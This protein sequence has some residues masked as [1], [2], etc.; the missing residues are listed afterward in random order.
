M[1]KCGKC[2]TEKPLSDFYFIQTTGKYTSYCRACYREYQRERLSRPDKRE[3]HNEWAREYA[4][5]RRLEI[6]EHRKMRRALEPEHR[7]RENERDRSRH[8]DR[9]LRTNYKMTR[10]QYDAK[11][12]A[13]GG[14]CAICGRE[15]ALGIGERNSF[16]VD[17]DHDCCP[18]R[19]TCGRCVRG[20]LC[21]HCNPMLGHVDE[22]PEVL[23]RAAEYLELWN[24]VLRDTS[25][26]A[27]NEGK[28]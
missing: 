25:A 21:N 7:E 13:Q 3:K 9:W 23:R 19:K 12:A 1:K 28:E 16:H 14:V 8:P 17:H 6:N 20:L 24:G 10:E 22:D 26:P 5:G 15:K 2:G 11:L 27:R 4:K 18:G